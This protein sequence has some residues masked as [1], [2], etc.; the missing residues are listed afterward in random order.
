[1]DER[2]KTKG[3]RTWHVF[4]PTVI[5]TAVIYVLVIVCTLLITTNSKKMSA[6]S[7]KSNECS[8]L[9]S[10]VLTHSSKLSDT[11]TTFVV[12][13]EIYKGPTNPNALNHEPLEQYILELGDESL[14]PDVVSSKLK[15]YKINAEA[16]EYIDIA[17][18]DLKYNISTQAHALRLLYL[19]VAIPADYMDVVEEYTLTEVEL[20][21]TKDEALEAAAGLLFTQEYAY[22][23]RDVARYIN[24]GLTSLS[25]EVENSQ[26][27]LDNRIEN[28]RITLWLLIILSM[29]VAFAFFFIF[30]RLLILP[31]LRFSKRINEDR[32]LDDDK[33]LYEA[34]FL[35][36]SYNSLLDRREE[37][38]E[39]LRIVAERDSLTGLLNRYSYNEFLKKEI[40]EKETA[41]VFMM[42]LNNLKHT[43]DTLGHDEGDKLIKNA[44]LCITECFKE[45][46][47]KCFR[48]GGD[49]FLVI[50]NDLDDTNMIEEIKAKFYELQKKYNVSIAMGYSYSADVRSI[51]YEK[52]VTEA[53]KWMYENKEILKNEGASR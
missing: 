28:L 17:I 30:L 24:L 11:I 7:K 16:K 20:A 2:K 14:D 10:S 23:K 36:T 5:L 1:M 39:Q 25:E 32:R 26:D 3:I 48:T 40:S 53:D 4:V 41:S 19:Y 31:I 42:D 50:V 49:E 15:N 9:V 38:E 8:N 47:A 35:A 29:V 44:A 12:T 6:E 18:E 21:Y 43:N 33:A 34:N 51:G 27:R 13:P 22:A 37:F 46:D 45:L 52:L